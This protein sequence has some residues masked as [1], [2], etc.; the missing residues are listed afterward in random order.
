VK[1]SRERILD[2][3]TVVVLLAAIGIFAFRSTSTSDSRARTSVQAEA[4]L[5]SARPDTL[6]ARSATDSAMTLID[7]RSDSGT[8]LVLFTTGCPYCRQTKPE[9]QRIAATLPASVR[10]I[11][12]TSESVS[13]DVQQ[14]FSSTRIRTMLLA[15]ESRA[16]RMFPVDVVP[17]TMAVRRGRVI[18][19]H[20]GLAT[21]ADVD[22]IVQTLT[23]SD[24][25]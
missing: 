19:A 13:L 11:A 8:V 14:Y 22:R 23:G 12:L 25:H 10:M 5:L 9:W 24:A 17:V 16:N 1:S 4:D 3:L 6:R 20:V 18:A 15:K 2:G 7:F 21:A